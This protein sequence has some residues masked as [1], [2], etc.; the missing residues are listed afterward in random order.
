MK[1]TLKET[2]ATLIPESGGMP[3]HE[4]CGVLGVG[5]GAEKEAQLL[6][7]GL[8]KLS[9]RQ[10]DDLESAKKFAMEQSIKHVLLRQTAA[11]QAN[12]RPLCPL[13]PL[14]KTWSSC[15]MPLQQQKIAMYAQALS[16]MARVYIGSISFE[17]REETIKQ[18]FNPF[19]PIK[20]INM[21]WDPVTGHH[22]GPP[23]SSHTW[24]RQREEMEDV[25]W[26]VCLP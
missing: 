11:H 5:P 22:K 17:I 9:R 26:R 13:L 19:G 2:L 25:N 21:S 16:L 4:Q 23:H 20:S 6:G 18:T 24:H 12:V 1:E 10:T 15:G 14:S 8:P 7:L 3:L